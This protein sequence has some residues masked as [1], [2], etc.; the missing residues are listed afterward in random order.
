MK[1]LLLCVLLAGPALA[2]EKTSVSA[3]KSSPWSGSLAAGWDSLYMFRGVNQLPGYAG[4]G[5]GIS[6][7]ALSFS[8][9][10]TA[11]DFFTVGSWV[12]FGVNQSTYKEVDTTFAYTRTLGDLSLSAGYALYAD[13]SGP[14]V[15]SNELYLS[16]AYQFRLGPVTVTPML[17]YTFTLGPRPGEGGY[18]DPAVSF[19]EFRVDAEIPLYRNLF[20]AAPWIAAG[21]NFGYN[22]TGPDDNPQPFNG[23]DHLEMGLALPYSLTRA[24]VVSPYVAYS[25][26]WR[27]LVGTRR[28]TFWGGASISFSF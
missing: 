18:K 26:S 8:W 17:D 7:T 1:H 5:S 13:L 23:A 27:P 25:H 11:H 20:S 24:I 10:P 14:G 9:T 12:A 2:E 16:A 6:W 3:E 19:L 21:V 15:Y 4:Y 22:S 28:D